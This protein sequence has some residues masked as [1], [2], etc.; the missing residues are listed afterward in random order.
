MSDDLNS[1]EFLLVPVPSAH[2]ERV[3]GAQEAQAWSAEATSAEAVFCPCGFPSPAEAEQFCCNILIFVAPTVMAIAIV[4]WSSSS[5][6]PMCLATA[7]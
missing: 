7:R 4:S 6:A 2:P 5:V 3:C 1:S